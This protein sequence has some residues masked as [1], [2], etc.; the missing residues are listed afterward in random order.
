MHRISP[1][2]IRIAVLTH[3]FVNKDEK[4]C[5]SSPFFPHPIAAEQLSSGFDRGIVLLFQNTPKTRIE[6]SKS[7]LPALLRTVFRK[8]QSI[9]FHL[10]EIVKALLQTKADSDVLFEVAPPRMLLTPSLPHPPFCTKAPLR[11]FWTS[12]SHINQD[13]YAPACLM[14]EAKEEAVKTVPGGQ[15]ICALARQALPQKGTLQQN[16]QGFVYL[17][18]SD[19]FITQLASLI[20]AQGYEPL[21][22]LS[23]DPTPAHIPVMTP[24]E[25]AQKKGWF[26][27]KNPAMEIPFKIQRLYSLQT[28][29][30]PGAEKVLFLEIHSL[31][32]E[33][34]REDCL[35]HSRLRGYPFYAVIGALRQK[36]QP[37]LDAGLFR[38]NV[39]CFAA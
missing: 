2:A 17:A 14:A 34:L 13:E 38:L 8:V 15:A 27:L 1:L 4:K 6:R 37:S 26:E 29:R 32:L 18:L 39:S 35:L 23:S 36:A 3:P 30:W 7:H 33:K 5:S 16:S 21:T 25:M 20:K 12:A 19:A 10:S 11:F 24:R 9:R 22:L 28:K 31:E